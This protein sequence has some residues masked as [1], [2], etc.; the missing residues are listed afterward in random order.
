MASQPRRWWDW[1]FRLRPW[2][3]LVCEIGRV[4]ENWGRARLT[5]RKRPSESALSHFPRSLVAGRLSAE[6]RIRKQKE[7]WRASEATGGTRGEEARRSASSRAK[8]GLAVRLERSGR[9]GKGEEIRSQKD[10]KGR[11][12]DAGTGW[13][14]W[15]CWGG[16]FRPRLSGRRCSAGAV[17]S[18]SA[19]FQGPFRAVAVGQRLSLIRPAGLR[20][21]WRREKKVHGACGAK[22]M[23]QVL[24]K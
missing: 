6:S 20:S 11:P 7:R 2:P 23:L 21:G 17:D 5:G 13:R 22:G 15:G 8:A 14:L 18:L 1:P 10:A 24:R 19:T 16:F 3:V 9:V 4:S 12:L